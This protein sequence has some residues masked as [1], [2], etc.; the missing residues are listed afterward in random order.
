M[1]IKE[2]A[3]L[4]NVSAATVSK[5]LNDSHEISKS[6]KER[7]LAMAGELNFQPNPNASSLRKNKN[8]TI[9]IVIPEIANNF[10]S[11][12]IDGIE[13]IAQERGYHLLI[14]LTHEKFQKEESIIKHLLNGR[15][16]GVLASISMETESYESFYE[17]KEKGLP[18]VLFDRIS[19]KIDAPKV[20]TD[21]YHAGYIGTKHLLDVGC[22][23]IGFLAFSE[24]SYSCQRRKQGYLDALTE[25]NI[26]QDSSL[27]INCNNDM[28]TNF[29]LINNLIKKRKKVDGIFA[30][31]E[32]L[33][34]LTYQICSELN[35]NIPKELKLVS[36]SNMPLASFLNPSLTTITQPA[37][38][39]GKEAALAL[40]RVIEKPRNN[41]DD[42][43]LEM[44]S[45]L[46]IRN[47]T[48][49]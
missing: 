29:T 39:M 14:Y 27:I 6:T 8:K 26:E 21:D 9:A 4:L 11:K 33:A 1:T 49:R 28:V 46:C 12:A 34:I 17:L 2:F 3:K 22:T 24:T 13:T 35:I 31:A 15:V 36:F 37:F 42:I 47:S 10:F 45:N 16:D 38:E 41:Y 19:D 23:K 20:C 40:F 5:A 43:L 7:V 25:C 18:L 30:S 32:N 44:K 48:K